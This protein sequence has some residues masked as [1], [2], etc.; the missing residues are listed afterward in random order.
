MR[1]KVLLAAGALVLGVGCTGERPERDTAAAAAT[2]GTSREPVVPLDPV[3]HECVREVMEALELSWRAQV[4]GGT[5]STADETRLDAFFERNAT[6]PR[7]TVFGKNLALGHGWITT[8]VQGGQDVDEALKETVTD[9]R[10]Y[11]E[12]DCASAAE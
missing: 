7:H 5:L 11:V 1:G 2:P 4:P 9:I 10:E 12:A 8:G 3:A 6:T